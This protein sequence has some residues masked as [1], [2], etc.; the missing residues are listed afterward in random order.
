VKDRT[1]ERE[2]FFSFFFR[3]FFFLLLHPEG[4]KTEE[5]GK[6][7]HLGSSLFSDLGF[8]FFFFYFIF[9][10]CSNVSPLLSERRKSRPILLPLW[11]SD[12]STISDV[13]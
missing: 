13:Q 5:R 12:V 2:E 3:A 10:L 8:F 6:K 11:G 7:E 9:W 1:S 4:E